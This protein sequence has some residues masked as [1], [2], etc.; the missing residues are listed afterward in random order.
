MD[1][2][3][4]ENNIKTIKF[5]HNNSYEYENYIICGTRGW[6]DSNAEEDVKILKRELLRLELS[7]NYGIKR[8]GENKKKIVLMHYPPFLEN[9]K[10]VNFLEKMQEYGIEYCIYGHIHGKTDEEKK[11]VEGIN[12]K[13]RLVSCDYLKFKLLLIDKGL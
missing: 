9:V 2:F 3:L 1:N 5:L 11:Y 7:L 12:V 8:F 10:E 13:F 4:K 6:I